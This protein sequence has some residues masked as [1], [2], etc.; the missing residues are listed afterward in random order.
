MDIAFYGLTF[1]DIRVLILEHCKRNEID[2]TFS[3]KTKLGLKYILVK[4]FVRYS[5]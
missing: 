4:Y 1:M 3:K 5:P 2:K